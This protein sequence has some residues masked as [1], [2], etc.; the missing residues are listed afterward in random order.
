ELERLRQ[1]LEAARNDPALRQARARR[2]L[3]MTASGGL[4][5]A[6]ALIGV[7]VWRAV[8]VDI[9]FAVA[10]GAAGVVLAVLGI[11]VLVRMDRVS[12]Q[13]ARRAV[14]PV[15]R[16]T[17]PRVSPPLHDQGPASWTPRPL[18]Q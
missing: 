4:L 2:R 5:V 9:P 15:P 6:V 7:G 8:V 14:D 12:R 11:A 10:A 13:A 3:R 18:P 17:E 16:R 1:E